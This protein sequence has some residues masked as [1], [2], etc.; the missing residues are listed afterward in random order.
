[1]SDRDIVGTLT[2]EPSI[3]GEFTPDLVIKGSMEARFPANVYVVS[4]IL[5]DRTGGNYTLSIDI[6]EI[7]ANLPPSG[8]ASVFGRTG[9]VTA[10]SGDYTFAQIGSK[11]TTLSGY[12]ITDA[13]PLDSDLTAIAALT[14][15]SYGRGLLTLA[16]VAAL[17][18][19]VDPYFLTPAEGNAAYQPLDSDLTAIAALTTTS[20]G[21]A[22]LALADAAA[23]RTYLSLV[24]GTDVQAYDSDLAALA[25]N[26]TNGLWA[27]TGA[28][29]GA[30]RTI[31]G[32]ANAIAVTN[33]DGVSGN[34][35][36]SISTDA[37][38]PGNPTTTT[39][40]VDNNTTRVATTAYVVGQAASAT[41]LGS[42]ATGVV[43]TS[44]RFARADHVHPGRETLTANRT[45]YVRTDGSD[46]NNGLANTSGGAFLT[47]QKAVDVVTDTLDLAGFA[48]TIQVG[49]GTY[50]GAVT[51]ARP[52]IGGTLTI[53]GDTTTPSNVLLN[54]TNVV[55]AIICVGRGVVLY[56]RG[57]KFVVATAGHGI[58]ANAGAVI[59]VNGNVDFGAMATNYAHIIAQYGGVV[60][61]SVAYLISA[62]A[63]YH[64]RAE[65]AGSMIRAIAATTCTISGS[66]AFGTAFAYA[67][68][69]ATIYALAMTYSG[70]VTGKR[71]SS[72]LNSVINTA[73][74]GANYF[75]GNSAGTTGT[76]GQYN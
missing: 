76:G 24:P 31:T 35:T 39:Q 36:L 64:Y 2:N 22:F 74:S 19:E 48:V 53:A 54:P 37:A 34:P 52:V 5:L 62:A 20:F 13:Q 47:I 29:T 8:V 70:T 67:D 3:T 14:T 50:T 23:T 73:G 27:R 26:S 56:V 21:R 66:P 55:A 17:V 46:S 10:Q 12:G 69:N 40:A 32:T 43:G 71:Y 30:A 49:N 25:A 61:I 72:T 65:I 75:P 45:Y 38:L 7:I 1:M 58:F 41:P 57:I 11:P 28:G 16:N 60:D 9:D 68:T 42:A 63:S 15:T 44:T 6:S 4:P 33:G 59:Y 18:T 51:M